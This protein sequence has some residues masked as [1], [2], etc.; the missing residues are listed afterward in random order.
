[1]TGGKD[2]EIVF[3]GTTFVSASLSSINELGTNGCSA[4]IMNLG[5]NVFGYST[6]TGYKGTIT[7]YGELGSE[8]NCYEMVVTRNS[9]TSLTL[10]CVKTADGKVVKYDVENV[11]EV[12]YEETTFDQSVTVSGN[13]GI[14]TYVD[15]GLPS[16]T[17]WAT[18]NVGAT[19][20]TEYG[21]YFAWGEIK[22]KK[23][24]YLSTYKWY[25]SSSITKYC[26]DS[27]YGTVDKKKVLEADDDAA[28]AN[29][30]SAWR[31][32]TAEEQ[33]E[34]IKGC[35]WK[36]VKYFNGSGVSGRLG[37]SKANG[38]TIFLP[39]AGYHYDNGL[40]YPGY[41][42]EYWSSSLSKDDPGRAN[43]LKVTDSDIYRFNYSRYYGRSVRAV[44]R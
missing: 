34:L 37:T 24:Y 7:V 8:S 32:P 44:L 17:M 11:A 16:G 42:G 26:T 1:M 21:D 25:S 43:I 5:N 18:Y 40:T 36:W 31:M 30:G 35:S 20:P 29:W 23:K 9:R 14:Y 28:T 27:D 33:D 38:A 2:V 39:A 19:K 4:T 12:Y 3:D 22:P 10:M 15:L 6:S 13:V 41:D